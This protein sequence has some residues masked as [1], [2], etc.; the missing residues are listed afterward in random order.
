MSWTEQTN[1]QT[2]WTPDL[3]GGEYSLSGDLSLN[4]DNLLLG[5]TNFW[6]EENLP[7]TTWT[8]Q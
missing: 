1:I 8:V 7:T 5:G 4:D 2:T 3:S 6:N